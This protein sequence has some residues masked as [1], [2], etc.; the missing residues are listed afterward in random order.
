MISARRACTSSVASQVGRKRAGAGTS[1]SGSGARG[2]S[3]SSAP[4]S[5]R[6]RL[7]PTRSTTGRGDRRRQTGPVGELGGG[8]RTERGEVPTGEQLDRGVLLRIAR[9]DPPLRVREQ[10][11]PAALPRPGRRRADE[12]DPQ[13]DPL[14]ALLA[15]QLDDR[16]ARHRLVA[17]VL[18]QP[19]GRALHVLRR[20]G[21]APRPHPPRTPCGPAPRRR[22]ATSRAGTRG[23]SSSAGASPGS[24]SG[25]RA[26]AVRASRSSPRP[27]TR[28]RCTSTARTAPAGHPSARARAGSARGC[29]RAAA[30]VRG[31][32]G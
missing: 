29:A 20:E 5:A 4:S 3:S 23:G 28:A 24:P 2:R 10:V 13:P 12:V 9:P 15:D 26:P 21:A 25:A 1:G 17:E 8:R 16:L 18:A 7:V 6:K 22:T 27:A 14:E 32:R 19:R 31:A 11:R 30:G